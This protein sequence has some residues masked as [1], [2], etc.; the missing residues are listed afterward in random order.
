MRWRAHLST[1]TLGIK[2][3]RRTK[4]SAGASEYFRALQS[5]FQLEAKVLTSVLPH[6]GERG[7]ND[8]ERFRSFLSRV[9][10]RKFS[11]G[12]GFVVCSKPGVPVSDQNDVVLVD[13]IDNSP[14]HRE[15]SAYVYPVEMVYGTIEVKASLT[16]ADLIPICESIKKIREAGKHR[17]YLKYGRRKKRKGKYVVSKTE[18]REIVSPRTFVFAYGKKNWRTIDDLVADLKVACKKTDAHIHGLA[19]LESNWFVKQK[20]H[21]LRGPQFS[22]SQSDALLRFTREL[23]HSIASL[24]MG[25]ASTDRYFRD[26]DA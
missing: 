22:M 5:I 19:I 23:L 18:V 26:L 7:R 24:R 1:Q 10:P 11:V 3:M 2:S 20:P 21:S 16:K 4:A 15:L 25:Q 12:T 14:L 9:L 6:L 8:E 17:W 13:E